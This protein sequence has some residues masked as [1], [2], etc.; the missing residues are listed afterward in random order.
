MIVWFSI[1]IPIEE[2]R[3][4]AAGASVVNVKLKSLVIIISRYYYVIKLD[5]NV[6]IIQKAISRNNNIL[7]VDNYKNVS[8]IRLNE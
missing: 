6:S 3:A 1:C 5:K 8:C 4:K 2:N 7:N